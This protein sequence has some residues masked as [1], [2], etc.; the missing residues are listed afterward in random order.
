MAEGLFFWLDI[1]PENIRSKAAC[2]GWR[3]ANKLEDWKVTEFIMK[4]E[5]LSEMLEPLPQR[6]FRGNL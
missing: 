6:Y 2:R 5:N 1:S 3:S 4:S